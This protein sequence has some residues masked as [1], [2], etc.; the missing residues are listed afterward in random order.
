[1]ERIVRRSYGLELNDDVRRSAGKLAA[2]TS[3]AKVN[4]IHLLGKITGE[5]LGRRRQIARWISPWRNLLDIKHTREYV[6]WGKV[7]GNGWI[8]TVVANRI[9]GRIIREPGATIQATTRPG[10]RAS[11]DGPVLVFQ[12]L[13]A[14]VVGAVYE[15]GKS[16]RRACSQRYGRSQ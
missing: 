15:R 11:R 14:N 7:T 5:I 8:H 9:A 10:K 1:M 16:K 4:T 13:E 12:G 6:T 3:W 2:S